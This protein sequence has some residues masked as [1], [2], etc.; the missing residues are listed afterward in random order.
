MNFVT[1]LREQPDIVRNYHSIGCDLL[2]SKGTIEQIVVSKGE[3]ATA[4][5]RFYKALET[6]HGAIIGPWYRPSIDL[7]HWQSAKNLQVFSGTFDNRFANWIDI[8]VLNST[9][10]TVV[11]TSR[12]MTP[13]VSEFA[14]AMT[15]NLIRH[16]PESL[17]STQN[18]N[19]RGDVTWNHPNFI[20][21]DLTGRRVGLAGFGS[22]NRRY[23]ELLEPF[24]CT[25]HSYDPFVADHVFD[26]HNIQRSESLIELAANS[27][28]FV[29]GLPPVPTTLE[30]IN[31]E[32]I[33][34]L[35]KG[36]LFVL[37]TRMAVVEQKPLWERIR[38]NEL[39]AAIDVFDPEPPPKDAWFR[40]HPNVLVTPHIA[41]GTDFC[42][43]RCFTHAC[44][45]A[46]SVIEGQQPIFQATQWDQ[47]CYAGKLKSD[48]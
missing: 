15:L 47:L 2:S 18:G 29:V 26:N 30:I 7:H 1:L 11:D 39:A 28:I 22:I 8:D 35:P 41:G 40:R 34:S 25:I 10:I 23:A 14:L 6:A 4:L 37:V 27:E 13:S 19:W 12:G 42:H 21:G 3:E 45:D 32:V 9:G 46:L 33:S 36:S 20:Y 31:R 16:I 5:D 17:N 24:R 48:Q 44:Q 38:A 43:R